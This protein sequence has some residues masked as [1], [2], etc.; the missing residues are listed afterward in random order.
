MKSYLLSYNILLAIGWAILLIYQIMNGFPIDRFSIVLLTVVQLAA[1]LEI[2]HAGLDWVSSPVVT[3]AM[4]IMSRVLVV[5]LIC[6][7]IS[8]EQYWSWNGISG[9]HLIIIAWTVTEIFRYFFYFTNLI[10]KDISFLK[11]MRYSTFLPLYPIGVTGEVLI[12]LSVMA[13][14]GWTTILSI[15][16]GIIL[17]SYV[18]L[19]PKMF[20]H[21]LNQRR[22]KLT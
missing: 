4:Q 22:K 16:L 7:F 6:F 17:I 15:L 5:F 18:V 11:T 10:G 14:L 9:W 2:V 20:G 8:P 13:V 19:F 3:T 1:L 21:M 12:I